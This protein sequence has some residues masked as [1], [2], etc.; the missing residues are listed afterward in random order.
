VPATPD[1]LLGALAELPL[2]VEDV[3]V[4]SGAAPLLSYP[5]GRRP[6]S[7]VTLVGDGVAGS[8]EHV[9]WSDAEHAAFRRAAAVAPRGRWRLGAWSAALAG[10]PYDRAALEAAAIDLA[11]RQA[12]TG[13]ARLAGGAPRPVR[14]VV[15]FARVADPV[16]EAERHAG[17]DLKVDVDPAW[18][19]A[20][21]RG[22]GS[23][24]RVA[25]L[26][27]KGEAGAARAHRFVPAALLEDAADPVAARASFDA[28]LRS[29]A[30]LDR[31]RVRPAAVN[32]KP[33]RMGGVLEA[34]RLIARA[35]AAGIDVYL[36]GMFEVDV[37][38]RQ[39][40]ALA[41][42]VCADGPNDVAPLSGPRPARIAVDP[43]APGFGG[44]LVRAPVAC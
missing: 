1:A 25:V 7:T 19:D 34:L 15:S 40:H 42:L 13:L 39:L 8:G 37:G 22:L 38:R 20:V 31:L 27:F 18:D 4:R 10:T 43:A 6:H 17:M 29:A 3:T 30:D 11:L 28:T 9:G 36:G 21:W 41:A 32:V 2:V 44:V 5:G 33:A 23:L 26:D 24:G 14:Y 35:A 16:A 12:D